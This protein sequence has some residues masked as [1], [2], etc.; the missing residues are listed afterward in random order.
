MVQSEFVGGNEATPTAYLVGHPVS[1]SS[2]QSETIKVVATEHINGFAGGTFELAKEGDSYRLLSNQIEDDEVAQF[3]QLSTFE[4]GR[5]IEVE[6]TSVSLVYDG[7]TYGAATDG[8]DD[9]VWIAPDMSLPCLFN[10]IRLSGTVMTMEEMLAIADAYPS[11]LLADID[12]AKASDLQAKFD[13][14]FSGVTT[15]FLMVDGAEYTDVQ[16]VRGDVLDVIVPDDVNRL[17]SVFSIEGTT[18]IKEFTSKIE[19]GVAV[20]AQDGL[21]SSD[22]D[23]WFALCPLEDIAEMKGICEIGIAPSELSK[24]AQKT[25]GL[26]AGSFS[27]SSLLPAFTMHIGVVV[28]IAPAVMYQHRVS[29]LWQAVEANPG[30]SMVSSE[31]I[32]AYCVA[33]DAQTMCDSLGELLGLASMVV[34]RLNTITTFRNP[35]F[36]LMVDEHFSDIL[37][38]DGTEAWHYAAVG[39][40]PNYQHQDSALR[41]LYLE[42]VLYDPSE[43]FGAG[44]D[45]PVVVADSLIDIAEGA[46]QTTVKE[47]QQGIQLQERN[48][49]ESAKVAFDAMVVGVSL[50]EI[51]GGMVGSLFPFAGK[52]VEAFPLD[53]C[54]YEGLYFDGPLDVYHVPIIYLAAGTGETHLWPTLRH[55]EGVY[56]DIDSVFNT[57]DAYIQQQVIP[58][59]PVI[60][61]L[62]SLLVPSNI[63]DP[64]VNGQE[65][66]LYGLFPN[67]FVVAFSMEAAVNEPPVL[68]IIAPMDSSEVPLSRLNVTFEVTDTVDFPLWLEVYLTREDLPLIGNVS[69]WIPIP[70]LRKGIWSTDDLWWWDSIRRSTLAEFFLGNSDYTMTIRARDFDGYSESKTVRF[71]ILDHEPDVTPPTSFV[72]PMNDYQNDL[73]FVLPVDMHDDQGIQAVEIWY[74]KDDGQWTMGRNVTKGLFGWDFTFSTEG[75]GNGAYRFYTRAIDY[76]NNYEAAPSGSDA[77]TFV[78]TV[79]PQAV[80]TG[81]STAYGKTIEVLYQYADAAP[82]SGP[83]NVSIYSCDNIDGILKDWVLLGYDSSPGD[84]TVLLNVSFLGDGYVGLI[85]VCLDNA[86][87]RDENEPGW[88]SSPELVMWLNAALPIPVVQYL[89]VNPTSDGMKVDLRW[90][91]NGD[92][93]FYAYGFYRSTNPDFAPGIATLVGYIGTQ[94]ST[95]ATITGLDAETIYYF[96]IRVY[97][98]DGFYSDSNKVYTRTFAAFDT[99][100]SYVDAVYLTPDTAWSESTSILGD[101]LDV[102]GVYLFAGETVDIQMLGDTFGGGDL[103]LR[104]G[105]SGYE[106]LASS[107]NLGVTEHISFTVTSDGY[108]YILVNTGLLVGTSWYTLW[109]TVI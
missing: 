30:S 100:G 29:D 55:I 28:S 50:K 11:S 85:A 23:L 43:F 3:G 39:I 6:V 25:M 74:S 90:S 45:V 106:L 48:G 86:G 69:I 89:P 102:F 81:P 94:S 12:L 41:H 108:Y 51:V 4:G 84:G 7:Y 59:H 13:F 46:V 2:D 67:G 56:I 78:D 92:H 93:D 19:M 22:Q 35:A 54:L 38:N 99:P 60:G 37:K 24:V 95:Q 52:V 101:S 34:D 62:L 87:N 79:P 65:N 31:S 98:V 109:I 21:T 91:A 83:K 80:V 77:S 68:N 16:T 70:M 20:I 53:L 82:S 66:W 18:W 9:Y 75:K 47:L 8:N 27:F 5:N 105:Y 32:N 40:V 15:K 33:I 103:F 64:I 42:G 10:T 73:S 71:R 72:R 36:L 14:A 104:S 97:D 96:V 107:Q 26:D 63:T 58:E 49:I 1:A 57:I 61:T 44:L 17:A 76:S 88:F